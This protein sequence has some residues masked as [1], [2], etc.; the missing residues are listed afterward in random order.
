MATSTGLYATD[1]LVPY[2]TGFTQNLTTEWK[3]IGTEEIGNVVV[4]SIKVRQ[5]DGKACCWNTW[6]WCLFDYY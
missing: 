5:D 2:F 6:N 1:S 3:Q 4:E